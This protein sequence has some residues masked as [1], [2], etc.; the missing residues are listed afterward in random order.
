MNF[1]RGLSCILLFKFSFCI[2]PR[3]AFKETRLSCEK[4]TGESVPFEFLVR[5]SGAY[6]IHFSVSLSSEYNKHAQDVTV[7]INEVYL[8]SLLIL[9][10]FYDP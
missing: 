3:D 9:S 5:K 2:S 4:T 10:Y 8:L 1:E 6:K 7:E